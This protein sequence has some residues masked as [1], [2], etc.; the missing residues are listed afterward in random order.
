MPGVPRVGRAGGSW[1]LRPLASP[2]RYPHKHV[3]GIH[4]DV[5]GP[6]PFSPGNIRFMDRTRAAFIAFLHARLEESPLPIAAWLGGADA[7]G[8]VDALSDVDLQLVVPD[9]GVQEAFG[10]VEEILGE[11]GGIEHAWRVPEPIW[12]GHSSAVYMLSAYPPT[13][14]LD[15]L[16]IRRSSEQW[17]LER[18]RHG[19]IVTLVDREDLLE[20]PGVD[21]R[22]LEQRR[23]TLLREHRA[24][25]PIHQQVLARTIARGH[26]FEANMRYHATIL[27]ALVDLMRCEHCPDRFDFG[28][29]YLDRDLPEEE[30]E[31]L[32][33]LS[34]AGSLEELA[35]RFERASTEIDRRLEMLIGDAVEGVN[36]A[37]SLPS[38]A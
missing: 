12:H 2:G 5:T 16:V 20:Q 3:V 13:M 29:R 32:E 22:S 15:L 38:E 18:E 14:C 35:E 7:T 10:L 36:A 25:Q 24:S 8:R 33:S 28:S 26:V 6:P 1:R 31:L 4:P 9:Q 19:S 37:G 17:L 27:K 23:N 11:C 34:M 21:R 30:R